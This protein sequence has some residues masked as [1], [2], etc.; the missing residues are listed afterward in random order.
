MLT[1]PFFLECPT[2]ILID[3]SERDQDR[4]PFPKAFFGGT[5]AVNISPV[6]HE[7]AREVVEDVSPLL[8]IRQHDEN[9]QNFHTTHRSTIKFNVSTDSGKQKSKT[10]VEIEGG[11]GGV[12]E[13]AKLRNSAS[14]I[15]CKIT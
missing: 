15:C 10:G 13:F 14:S 5:D 6:Q 2:G 1:T 4:V 9:I 7:Y 3:L 11:G 8:K 12:T